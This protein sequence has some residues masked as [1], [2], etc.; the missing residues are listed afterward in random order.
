MSSPEQI[1]KRKRIEPM[2][3]IIGW[4]TPF[5]RKK[6]R[7]IEEATVLFMRLHEEDAQPG[8]WNA[9]QQ[10]KERSPR[11]REIM[12]DIESFWDDLDRLP[13]IP[14]ASHL[15]CEMDK[16][17][18]SI[19]LD[20]KLGAQPGE[21]AP[22]ADL[23][24]KGALL[25]HLWKPVSVS[26]AFLVV[27]IGALL[28]SGF[29]NFPSAYQTGIGEHRL[30]TLEDGSEI[31]LGG[32]SAVRVD[33]SN[34]ARV[35]VLDSG[36]ALFTVA[37]DVKRPFKVR[38]SNALVTAIGT[39]FN[40]RKATNKV[41]VSVTEGVVHLS[42]YNDVGDL[43]LLAPDIVRKE[44]TAG[45]QVSYGERGEVSGIEE[46]SVSKMV[47]WRDG[48]LIYIEE[49]LREVV[50]D[51]NRYYDGELVIEDSTV[52][53]LLFTGTVRKDEI[54]DWLGGLTAVFPVRIVNQGN[55]LKIASLYQLETN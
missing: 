45:Q 40:I 22:D 32:K 17:D 55:Q 20:T 23:R 48:Q 42:S 29:F 37:K 54:V 3:K 43:K 49:P 11:H 2:R 6:R 34:D 1:R 15:E 33:F 7:L 26:L 51:I 9:Y 10:W 5:P 4:C 8:D 30:V 16:Y 18:G 13:Q 47:S 14:W 35:V 27:G 52:A 46:T 53:D 38:V 19:P 39:Q 50:A 31:L 25:D 21:I 28:W 24:S 36:E 12:N 41:V 44:L